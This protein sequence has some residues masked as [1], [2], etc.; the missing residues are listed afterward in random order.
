MND[1]DLIGLLLVFLVWIITLE[2]VAYYVADRSRRTWE[3]RL[4]PVTYPLALAEGDVLTITVV[5][6]PAIE[7]MIERVRRAFTEAGDPGVEIKI[8]ANQIVA[9]A[10]RGVIVKEI[11]LQ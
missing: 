4:R 10:T 6:A 1:H 3:D 2:I 8:R 9:T 7:D 5:P 11:S